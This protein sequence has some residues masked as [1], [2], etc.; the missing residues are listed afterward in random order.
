MN[1]G[2]A[3]I[4]CHLQNG[5]GEAPIFSI[6]GTVFPTAHEPNNCV[7]SGAAGAVVEIRDADGHVIDLTANSS[8]NFSYSGS[9]VT[10]YAAKVMYQGRE[11]VMAAVQTSGDCNGCH[12]QSGS[13]GAPGR[14]LLP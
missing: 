13:Q 2:Q 11:R 8:G 4:S 7:A 5:E 3:C 9:I 14:I 6:A 10:P 1:P 12:T